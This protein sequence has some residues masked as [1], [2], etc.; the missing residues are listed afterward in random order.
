MYT[1]GAVTRLPL[2]PSC[3]IEVV[4]GLATQTRVSLARREAV[5]GYLL[6]E[7]FWNPEAYMSKPACQNCFPSPLAS[8]PM[9]ASGPLSGESIP[10]FL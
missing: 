10:P 3:T 6:N 2:L 4:H 5:K 9:T 7:C 8:S 1:Q